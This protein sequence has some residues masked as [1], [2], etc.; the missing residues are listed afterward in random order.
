MQNPHL[1]RYM[2]L[3]MNWM[4][5]VPSIRSMIITL[6]GQTIKFGVCFNGEPNCRT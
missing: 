2:A 3:S 6:P 5:S 1:R 4:N